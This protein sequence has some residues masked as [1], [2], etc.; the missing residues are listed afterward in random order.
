MVNYAGGFTPFEFQKSAIEKSIDNC[1]RHG[2][3]AILHQTGLGKTFIG[4]STAINLTDNKKNILIVSPKNN[5]KAWV[6]ILPNATVCTKAKIPNLPFDVIIVDE[7]HNFANDKNKSYQELVRAIYLQAQNKFPYVILLSATPINNNCEEFYNM[8]RLIPFNANS[9]MFWLLPN[10]YS[11][12][13]KLEKDI[14]QKDIRMNQKVRISETDIT[15]MGLLSSK[16]NNIIK[17]IASTLSLFTVRETRQ[18]ITNNYPND[19]KLLGLF[20][21]ITKTT[22][23]YSIDESPIKDT[24]LSIEGMPFAYYNILNYTETPKKNG[25]AG[26]MK[27]LLFKRLDS[28]VIAFKS[29]LQKIIDTISNIEVKNNCVKVNDEW[30]GVNDEF[31]IDN[32]KDLKKLRFIQKSWIDKNDDSKLIQLKNIIDNTDGV[33]FT[34]NDTRVS[35]IV[36]FTEYQATKDLI[37]NYLENYKIITYDSKTNEKVLDVIAANFDAN[38]DKK[39]NKFQILVTTDVLSEGVNLHQADILIHFDTKWNPSRLTQREGRVDRIIK[40]N[41]LEKNV[42]VFTFGVDFLVETVIKLEN[43]ITYKNSVSETILNGEQFKYKPLLKEGVFHNKNLELRCIN[44]T[45]GSITFSKTHF[46]QNE[47]KYVN[48][49]FDEFNINLNF[50]YRDKFKDYFSRYG[51]FGIGGVSPFFNGL[52]ENWYKIT[53]KK[54]YTIITYNFSFIQLLNN[55]SDKHKGLVNIQGEVSERFFENFLLNGVP[56]RTEI[57]KSTYQS[58]SEIVALGLTETIFSERKD[59]L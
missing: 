43:K 51:D 12:L 18:G 4:A 56:Y 47:L 16:F 49:T 55:S 34:A 41:T 13:V 58:E 1:Y 15:E 48:P 11:H 23:K 52:F 27:C 3:C 50:E 30:V 39:E 14:K 8:C 46:L 28:S 29:T 44:F 31:F 25:F 53:E 9:P 10:L 57:T 42:T 45:E 2:G 17:H 59:L 5:Q 22:V 32:E 19:I 35:K 36:I 37:V 54:N 26:I 21:K 7:A 6:D 33:C 38:I 24:I 20:P 40:N